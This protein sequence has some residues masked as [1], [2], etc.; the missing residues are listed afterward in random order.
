M[1]FVVHR[2]N[3][4]N[5]AMESFKKVFGTTRSYGVY[6]GNNKDKDKD[7]LFS[8]IQTISKP[9]RL[10]AFDKDAFDY[11]IIDESHRSGAKSYSFLLEYFQPGFL[12]GMTATPERTD[13]LDIFQLFDHNIAYEI[14]LN[15][16]MEEDLLCP[17]HYFGVSDLFIDHQK[18]DKLTTFNQL[19]SKE[20]VEKVIEKSRFFGTDNGLVRG[21]IFCSRNEEAEKLSEL[22]NE[23]GLQ[24]IALSG[25]SSEK[26]RMTAIERLESDDLREK[27]DYILSVD[28]FNE[29]VDIPKVNQ[30][31]MLRPTA[32]AIIFVQ[33]LGRGLRKLSSKS[34]LTV[35]DFI[36]NHN[37]NYLIPMALYG[38]SSY[39]KDRIRKL[40][41]QGSSEI[42]GAS[43]INFDRISK[44]QIFESINAANLS[45]LKDLRSD[46][47]YLKNRLGRI[48]MMEDFRKARMRDAFQF[49]IYSNSYLNFVSKVESD[50]SPEL[51]DLQIKILEY[52]AGEINNSKR[53]EESLILKGLLLEGE[54][55]FQNLVR[56]VERLFSYRPS[57]ET[58]LSA[59]RNIN[60]EFV[61]VKNSGSLVP[62]RTLVGFGVIHMDSRRKIQFTDEFNQCLKDNVFREFLVDNVDFGIHTFQE[63][64]KAEQWQNGFQFYE[65]YSR[66]DVFRIMNF[67]VNPVA[68]NVGG[69]LVSEE[70]GVCPIFV[71]YHKEEDISESTKYEDEF[72]SKSVFAWMS[73]SNRKLK[74]KDVQSILNAEGQM[75]LPLFVKKS[76]DEGSDFYY[77]ADLLPKKESA[78][79]TSMKNDKG[80]SVSVVRME[81]DLSQQVEDG[82]YKY[83]LETETSRKTPSPTSVQEAVLFEDKPRQLELYSEEASIPFYDFYAAAGTFSELQSAGDYEML[84]VPSRFNPSIHFACKVQGESM[85]KRIPNGSIC[86]FEKYDGGSRNDKIVLVSHSEMT[87]ADYNSSFT[88]KTFASK[89]SSIDNTWEH[90]AIVLKPNSTDPSFEDIVLDPEEAQN[91][92]V[93]GVFVEVLS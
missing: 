19:V 90:E 38:D 43:T 28:I 49:V 86:I 92:R 82:I 31:I 23:R 15:D 17:F 54:F 13:G 52:F 7:F 69:Y 85:N 26:E 65:K 36:G 73:K 4:A 45:T 14:R 8:T 24:T 29:G 40:I 37:G 2:L 63:K 39:N 21:L 41:S 34:Y 67:D 75:R 44:E 87:F 32:S 93:L 88:V 83:L 64:F 60:M 77:I 68:Q 79:E 56:E 12:L 91:M 35:I 3:I 6:S 80:K 76:N 33:Q 61:R 78:Q 42:P 84:N 1:L 58:F 57:N 50:F 11:I 20:R 59:V 10:K 81:F 25:S 16:A 22:L 46:Y 89:K 72:L 30:V 66:K 27:L 9:E 47:T 5:K 53:V 48:P 51:N 18:Q 62:F 74:S 70:Q 71:N 55:D